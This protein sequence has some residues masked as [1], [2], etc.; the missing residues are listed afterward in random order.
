MSRLALTE[1]EFAD[2]KQRLLAASERLRACRTALSSEELERARAIAE[3]A[4]TVIVVLKFQ[5][6]AKDES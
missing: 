3:S 6:T 5:C 4:K 2:S 1:A